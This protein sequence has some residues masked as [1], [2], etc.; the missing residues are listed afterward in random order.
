MTKGRIVEKRHWPIWQIII[1]MLAI[2]VAIIFTAWGALRA[3]ENEPQTVIAELAS[4][5]VTV[6]P[7]ATVTRPIIHTNTPTYTP[8]PTGTPGPTRT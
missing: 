6:S 5:T 4:P 8:P 7:T 3:V 2:V 1:V